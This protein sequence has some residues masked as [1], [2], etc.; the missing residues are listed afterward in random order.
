MT[1]EINKHRGEKL[2][3]EFDKSLFHVY[4]GMPKIFIKKAKYE[5]KTRSKHSYDVL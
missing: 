3:A 2:V 1:E 4:D 5:I